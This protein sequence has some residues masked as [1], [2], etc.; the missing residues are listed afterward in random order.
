[1]AGNFA[2]G[3][4]VSDWTVSRKD[5]FMHGIHAVPQNAPFLWQCKR[6]WPVCMRGPMQKS[7][8]VTQCYAGTGASGAQAEH[9]R[10]LE[11][12]NAALNAQLKVLEEE[13]AQ[14]VASL[15][16]QTE[17]LAA[18]VERADR[19]ESQVRQLEAEADAQGRQI[20]LLEVSVSLPS[21]IDVIEGQSAQSHSGDVMI[22]LCLMGYRHYAD[23]SIY[24]TVRFSCSPV[25]HFA[26]GC[27]QESYGMPECVCKMCFMIV[28]HQSNRYNA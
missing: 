19:A 12:T 26:L 15:R 16:T 3:T 7:V 28:T 2:P 11:A 14:Q 22:R 5:A 20:A 1:M 13:A 4:G 8:S 6:T 10:E 27:K 9:V 25:S 24:F 18:A 21:A 23:E 17:K